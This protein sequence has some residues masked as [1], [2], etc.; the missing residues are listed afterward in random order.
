MELTSSASSGIDNKPAPQDPLK[1]ALDHDYFCFPEQEVVQETW[2]KLLR[3]FCFSFFERQSFAR[4]VRLLRFSS[5]ALLP[6]LQFQ[7]IQVTDFA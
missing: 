6:L 7:F 2:R 3:P 4:P 5:I 1:T